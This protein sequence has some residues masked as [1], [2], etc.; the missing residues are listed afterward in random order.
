MQVH[1]QDKEEESPGLVGPSPE[2]VERWAFRFRQE[3]DDG[4]AY[5]QHTFELYLQWLHR[6]T[7]LHIKA[8]YSDSPIEEDSD[9]NEV[10]D[11]YD[12]STLHG[13]QP[14]RAPLQSYVVIYL[15]VS[16]L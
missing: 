10:I 7:K 14:E 1:T 6:S 11:A 2:H 8:P 3:W 15:K 4:E 13:N 12:V 9:D 16:F 5:D